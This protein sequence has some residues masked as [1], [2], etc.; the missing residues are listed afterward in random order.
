ASVRRAAPAIPVIDAVSA[1]YPKDFG[2]LSYPAKVA[3]DFVA[4]PGVI[5]KDAFAA[6]ITGDSMTPR[7]REG[8]IVVFSPAVRPTDGDDCFVRLADGYTAFKRIF[9]EPGEAGWPAVRL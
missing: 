5:D 9:F 4:C 3:R 6:R 1:G 8:D 2:D 7:Y